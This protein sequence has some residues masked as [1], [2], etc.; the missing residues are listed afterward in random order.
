MRGMPSVCLP[1]LLVLA[2]AR[3][4]ADAPVVLNEVL[5]D[6]LGPDAGAE[7]VELYNPGREDVALSGWRLEAGNGAR[8]NDWR[9]VWSGSSADR[10]PAGGFFLAAGADIEAQADARV[11]LQLQN[12]PDAVRLRSPA[13]IVDLVGWGVHTHPEYVES[14]AA[15]DVP[16]GWSLARVPDGADTDCNRIDLVGRPV[17]SPG[18]PN[19][20]PGTILLDDVH[21]E[22]PILIPEECG[23]LSVTL[24]NLGSAPLPLDRLRWKLSANGVTVRRPSLPAGTLAADGWQRV[25]WEIGLPGSWSR[26]PVAVEVAVEGP[27]VRPASA[28][29]WLRADHGDVL[30]S[31]VQYDP[32][33]DG[34]EWIELFNRGD[35]PVELEGWRLGDASGRVTVLGPARLAPGTCAL[36]ADSEQT[37]RRRWPQ[38]PPDL[39]V[40][41]QGSWPSLNNSL[42]R[43][44]GYA[45]QVI[46][47]DAEDRPVDFIRYQPG[48]LDGGG[49]TLERW[50][51]GATLMAPRL[52]MACAAAGGATPGRVAPA[53]AA[54]GKGSG[55]LDPTPLR[56]TPDRPDAERLCRI[57]VPPP[58]GGAG[59][60]DAEIYALSGRRVATLSAG[61]QVHGPSVLLWDGRDGSGQRLPTGLYLLRVAMADRAEGLQARVTRPIALV[62]GE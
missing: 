61:A 41:R 57:R 23:R 32:G 27:D 48:G 35:V 43:D 38:L 47:C 37:L 3:A 56:L 8:P 59:S 20:R 14:S 42:D 2:S 31:E 19:A 53:R 36:V 58:P 46:L 4:A 13:G 18:E 5:Y 60:L 52:L 30:I 33:P 11:E 62:R 44:L 50:I 45:D 17:P 6:P 39:C 21:C 12:G 55:W 51:E 7:F 10:I 22:P 34:C 24:M 28:R 29:L 1:L 9:T 15:D 16:S 49:V 26:G 25:Q 40:P 54:S